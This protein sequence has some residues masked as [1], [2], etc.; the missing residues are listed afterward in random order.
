METREVLH[1]RVSRKQQL[2]D[3]LRRAAL[4]FTDAQIE[5]AWAISSAHQ[6][7]LSIR[8]I[9]AATHLSPSRVHQV[10]N[11]AEATDMPTWLSR[12]REA[13][14]AL[15]MCGRLAEEV[16]ILRRCIDWLGQME[17]GE[18]VVVNLRLDTDTETEYVPFDRARV[19]RILG[20]IASDLDDLAGGRVVPSEGQDD[21]KTRHR[22]Q[23][24]EP[25]QRPKKLS[26]REERDALRA[27]LKLPR[28]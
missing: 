12:L 4:H 9:A 28:K 25:A 15:E 27:K 19:M 14:G 13:D 10:L 24:A 21:P 23:L 3:C 2:F 8:R 5:R 20:R 22:R 18:N 26:T 6:S 17:R 11:S 16:K 1:E 7:G